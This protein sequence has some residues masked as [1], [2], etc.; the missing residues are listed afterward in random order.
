MWCPP[1]VVEKEVDVGSERAETSTSA[2]PICA[3]CNMP[4]IRNAEKYD[5][6]EKTQRAQDWLRARLL[7]L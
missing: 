4:V 7:M 1:D 2:F 6:C 3:R 5:L